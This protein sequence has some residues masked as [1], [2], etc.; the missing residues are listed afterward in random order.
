[1][2]VG[3]DKSRWWFKIFFIFIPIWGRFP[4]L[5]NIFQM[6]W[7]HQL[8]NPFKVT[9]GPLK[10]PLRKISV[11]ENQHG[12]NKLYRKARADFNIKGTTSRDVLVCWP[13]ILSFP[14]VKE[15][16]TWGG[17]KQK[18]LTGVLEWNKYISQHIIV[19]KYQRFGIIHI[20]IY[21]NRYFHSSKSQES[22]CSKD[23]P[24]SLT[25]K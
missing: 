19:T 21:Q 5:T 22:Q 20:Y 3:L 7:N 6:G 12:R 15:T 17:I 9:N 11:L 4:F 2:G 16:T 25:L 18:K 1:M 23:D 24:M 14:A 13:E 10:F 8:V